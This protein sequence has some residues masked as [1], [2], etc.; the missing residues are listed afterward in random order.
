MN[1]NVNVNIAIKI[2]GMKDHKMNKHIL[3]IQ[4]TNINK[5]I[6]EHFKNKTIKDMS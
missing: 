4:C 5:Y 6:I 2:E 3:K 1:V